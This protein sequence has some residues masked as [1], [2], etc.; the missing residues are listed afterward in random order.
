MH[1][2]RD[3]G[4]YCELMLPI[5]SLLRTRGRAL[6]RTLS[7]PVRFMANKVT[8]YYNDVYEVVLPPTHRFPMEKYR[9]VRQK[10]QS[11]FA[12]D[13]NVEFVESPLATTDELK[14]THCP[15]YVDRYLAGR[16]TESETRKT[17]FPHNQDNI[18]RACSSA[19]GTVAATRSVLKNKDALFS[20]HLA[21]G[22][23]HAFYDYG[24]GFCVFSDIAVACNL[25]LKEYPDEVKQILII[26]L[27]V[28]Q[29]NGNAVIFQDDPRVFT[30][31]MHCKDNYFSKK[32]HSNIDVEVEAGC[33]DEEYLA[34]LNL[35]LPI[36][37]E[38]VQPQLVFFQA[39]VDI[40]EGDRLGKLK[41]TRTGLQQRN[42]AVYKEIVKRKIKCVVTMGGG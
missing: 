11:E 24:E 28:H 8:L 37:F 10:L 36:L 34:K 14:L 25:A 39:G 29:G 15:D 35:W 9:L 12:S 31:S 5:R 32:E 19:G 20:G 27:D 7:S 26:D 30:F 6:A 21:G 18:N 42:E 4:I 33:L 23:H 17:G 41:I 1:V 40:Y 13:M 38:K 22:T 2:P 3:R 16:L